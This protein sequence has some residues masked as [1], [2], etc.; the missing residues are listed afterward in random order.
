MKRLTALLLALILLMPMLYGCGGTNRLDAV[1]IL[2]GIMGSELFLE[3]DTV[4][5]GKEYK[6]DAKLWLAL[7]SVKQVFAVPE[8]ISMLDP[9][10]GC[11]I[12]TESPIVN[13]YHSRQTYGTLNTYKELYLALYNEFGKKCDVVFYSYD[14]RMDPYESARELDEFVKS[15]GYKRISIVARGIPLFCYGRGAAREDTYLFIPR[16]AVSWLRR[17]GIR[18]DN[19]KYRLLFC[20]HYRIERSARAM[21]EDRLDVRASAVQASVAEHALGLFVDRQSRL[22]LL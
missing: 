12:Q 21:S 17:G 19:G 14:W 6:A 7:D 10:A 1:I 5:D 20:Q 4:F 3:E 15:Q 13:Y 16:N 11:N 8:H 9:S 22:R 18:Y 2:P